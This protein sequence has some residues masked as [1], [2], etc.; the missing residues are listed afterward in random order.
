MTA[1]VVTCLGFYDFYLDV[2]FSY[3]KNWFV[4]VNVTARV[5]ACLGCSDLNINVVF[6]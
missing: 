3:V 6:A 5:L 1:R 2:A 4:A